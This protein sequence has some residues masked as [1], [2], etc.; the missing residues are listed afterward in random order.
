MA[1]D[2]PYSVIV[3]GD[4]GQWVWTRTRSRDEAQV[5]ADR[6][7]AG[8]GSASVDDARHTDVSGLRRRSG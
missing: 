2:F 1:S 3:D 8:G 7:T 4:G 5:I 6:I